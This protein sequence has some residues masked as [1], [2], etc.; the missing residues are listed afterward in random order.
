MA[1]ASPF[2]DTRVNLLGMTRPRLR[3]FFTALGVREYHA[4]QLFGWLYRHGV[5]EYEAMTNL[6]RSLRQLLQ[7]KTRIAAPTLAAQRVSRDGTR[8]W[9]LSVPGGQVEAVLIP[10]EGR[11]TLCISSQVGCMLDCPFCSTGKQGFARNLESAEIIAQV[12]RVAQ[13]L[14]AEN[15]ATGARQALSNVVMMGMGEPLLNL[16]NVLCALDIL[17]DEMGYGISRRRLTLSTAG[18]AP[19]IEEL[20]RR[21]DVSLAISLHAADNA[22]RDQLVPINR[23]YPIEE[24]L[25]ACRGYVRQGQGSKRHIT[26]EYTLLDGVNDRPEQAAALARLLGGLPCKINLIPFNPWPGAPYRKPARERIA[27][28]WKVLHHAGCRVMVRATRGDDIAAACGQLAGLVEDRT[29]RRKRWLQ[30]LQ[31]GIPSTLPAPA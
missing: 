13:L 3:A 6:P 26:V 1:A 27:A 25:R 7:Q 20:A 22:L 19:A 23:K 29:Q 4:D 11:N 17:R 14:Q 28:F 24:L 18:V 21:S 5:A 30:Q 15:R 8:K 9:L 31:G 16:E 10:E 2:P 12:W